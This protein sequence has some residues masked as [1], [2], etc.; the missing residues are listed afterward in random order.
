MH[1]GIFSLRPGRSYIL[2]GVGVE[3]F[4]APRTDFE[5]V[6]GSASFDMPTAHLISVA[7][8]QRV[9]SCYVGELG[10]RRNEKQERKSPRSED[11]GL[12]QNLRC[13]QRGKGCQFPRAAQ[14]L[15]A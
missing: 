11:R 13:L 8:K 14:E 4:D 3:A 1:G 2:R 15:F 7:G 6:A 9:D 12:F 5:I 10:N